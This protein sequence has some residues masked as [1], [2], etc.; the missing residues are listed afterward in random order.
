[1]A[2]VEGM[3]CSMNLTVKEAAEQLGVSEASLYIAIKAERLKAERIY[4]RLTLRR[5]EVEAY[6]KTI[7][8]RNGY[9]KGSTKQ[10]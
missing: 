4:G 6:G 7:G 8:I 1:M 3:L 5:D 9:P 10:D 2:R